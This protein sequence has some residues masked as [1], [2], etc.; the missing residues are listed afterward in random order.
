MLTAITREISPAIAACQLTFHSRQPID[1][2][3]AKR[4][5]GEYQQ[6]LARLGARVISLPAEPELPD[7]IFVEDTALVLDEV[8]V[9]LPMGAASRRAEKPSIEKALMPFRPIA[10]IELPA[11]IEGGDIM[12]ID[13]RLFAGLSSRTNQEGIRQLAALVS[14]FG[15]EVIAVPVEGCLHLKSA[16]TFLGGDTIVG[17]RSRIDAEMFRKFEWIDVPGA[18]PAAGNTLTIRGKVILPA[19]FPLTRGLLEQRG[20]TVEGLDISELQKAESGLTCSSLVF[21]DRV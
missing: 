18:E 7:A 6:L 17:N 4:Q 3:G 13:R 16:C 10:K 20:F 2:A 1:F 21:E 12:R 19:S 15:Y 5:H 9:L 8:A 11:K 14:R